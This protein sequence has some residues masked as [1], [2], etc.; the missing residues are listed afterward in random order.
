MIEIRLNPIETMWTAGILARIR[1]GQGCPRSEIG[2]VRLRLMS[3]GVFEV[4][5]LR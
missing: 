3:R 2:R 1:S 5:R 4:W